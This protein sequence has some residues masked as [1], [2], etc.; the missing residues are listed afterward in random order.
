MNN[1]DVG[2]PYQI[3]KPIRPGHTQASALEVVYGKFIYYE[4][5]R[6]DSRRKI[7]AFQQ[8][9]VNTQKSEVAIR[10]VPDT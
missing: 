5:W 6:G 8:R 10:V 1:F 4:N 7:T 2:P 3:E 9:G